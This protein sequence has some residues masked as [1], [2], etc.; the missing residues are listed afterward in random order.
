MIVYKIRSKANNEMFLNGTPTY[1][2]WNKSG[3]IFQTMGKLRTFLTS[4]IARTAHNRDISNWEIVE[5]EMVEKS[6]KGVHEVV[7]PKTLVKILT[8]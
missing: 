8:R 6:V 1:N 5:I 2:S 3:R 4:A 7:T